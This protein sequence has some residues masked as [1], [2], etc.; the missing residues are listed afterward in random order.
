[1][2]PNKAKIKRDTSSFSGC[3]SRGGM[4]CV[5]CPVRLFE[6]ASAEE[7]LREKGRFCFPGGKSICSL[8]KSRRWQSSH[9]CSLFTEERK[10]LLLCRT[11]FRLCFF[12]C[13]DILSLDSIPI[14]HTVTN[15]IKLSLFSY[16]VPVEQLWDKMCQLWTR[17]VFNVLC[18][19]VWFILKHAD[20]L[21][22]R[23]YLQLQQL[24]PAPAFP[25]L[26]DHHIPSGIDTRLRLRFNC[27][28]YSIQFSLFVQP[29]FTN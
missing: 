4:S 22:F 1:M 17:F 23:L 21:A 10:V 12:S 29:I 6:S 14:E 16:F 13:L 5:K 2:T 7:T 28:I 20:F 19:L 25:L 9:S 15:R 11:T 24:H 3:K 18:I 26:C 27:E 8:S